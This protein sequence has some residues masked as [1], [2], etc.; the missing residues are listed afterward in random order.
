VQNVSTHTVRDK[1]DHEKMR[2]FTILFLLIFLWSCSNTDSSSKDNSQSTIIDTTSGHNEAMNV[3]NEKTNYI[4]FVNSFYFSKGNEVYID[5]Y[6]IKDETD[7][8]EYT[9]ITKLADSVIYTDDENTRYKFPS[10]ISNKYF[11]LRGLSKLNIYD[12]K[13][14]FVCNASFVRVEYLDQNIS[15]SFIAV[16]KTEKK[17]GSDIFY[18]VSNFNEKLESLNYSIINDTL[19][20]KKILDKL[21]VA[22][23]YYGL[24]NNG[25]H[26]QHQTSDTTLSIVNSDTCSFIVLS[27][28]S[29]FEVLYKSSEPENILNAIIIPMTE[30]KLPYILTRIAMPESDMMWDELLYFDGT[31]YKTTNR[32]RRK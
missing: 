29:E 9:R 26:V 10:S 23:P 14:N 30:N 32:Q 1:Q 18:C 22:R 16:Y 11:D 6:F 25:T 5:L 2:T 27:T 24:E 17:L 20:T 15:P 8:N 21:N 31:T 19:L 3:L 28:N 13:N 4:G 7:A 12:T